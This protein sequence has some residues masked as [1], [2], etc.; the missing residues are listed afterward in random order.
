MD[1]L[2]SIWFLL[3]GILKRIYWLLPALLLDPFDLAERL[4]KVNYDMPQWGAWVLASLGVFVTIVLTYHELR[5][6]KVALER[7]TNWIDAYKNR[8]GR[9]PPVPDYL[10]PVVHNYSPGEHVSKEIQLRTP[11]GQFW[12]RLLPSQRKQWR[13]LVEWLGKDPEDYL[14]HMRMM[15]P[16][17]PRGVDRGRWTPFKQD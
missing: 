17:T 9:L 10:L 1:F 2:K 15:S 8:H 5:M 13:E 16:Q 11:S 12:N 14:A 7:P 4:F 6:Q 3:F